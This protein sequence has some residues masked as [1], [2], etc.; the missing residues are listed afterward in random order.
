MPT[1]I[2]WSTLAFMDWAPEEEGHRFLT[3]RAAGQLCAFD[4]ASVRE[5]VP[6]RDTTR[7]PGAPAWVL[8]LINLRGTL[9][10][11]ID[12]GMRFEAGEGFLTVS[13]ARSI[14]V[15]ESGGRTFGVAVD[16]VRDVLT[17]RDDVVEPV[18]PQRSA[19]GIVRGLAYVTANT[20]GETAL[21]C[22]IAA[23]AIQ[24]LAA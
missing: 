24:A 18:D 10:T 4:L 17:V 7:L 3:C 6:V 22:D 2:R 21:V 15:V 19:G 9:V 8:G 16:E 12:L 13:G 14:V 1:P 20:P 23:I 5:I 11:V